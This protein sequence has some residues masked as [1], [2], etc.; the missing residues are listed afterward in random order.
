[1]TILA[2]EGPHTN[3]KA[4]SNRQLMRLVILINTLW[5]CAVLHLQERGNGYGDTVNQVFLCCRFQLVRE[6]KARDN[7]VAKLASSY[8]LFHNANYN[9]KTIWCLWMF[10]LK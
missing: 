1:M 2:D 9:G 6:I 7:D 4:F 5:S 3:L 10:G 8:F